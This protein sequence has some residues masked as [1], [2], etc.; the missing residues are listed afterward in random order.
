[1]RVLYVSHFGGLGGAEHSLLELIMAVRP[2][3]V[4]PLLICPPGPLQ[5]MAVQNKIAVLNWAAHPLTRS[6][7]SSGL[8]R[9]LPRLARGWLRLVQTVE[10]FKPDVLHA[11][12]MQAML[13]IG[14]VARL[15]GCR[16]VWHW[17][18]FYDHRRQA[19]TVA[20]GADAIV[21]I[22]R[23]TLLFAADLLGPTSP[24]LSLIIN[25]V[26]DL[27]PC[28]TDQINAT[29]RSL[30]LLPDSLLVLMAGQS[31]PRKGHAVLIEAIATVNKKRSD[32]YALLL[33]QEH[34]RSAASYTRELRR[35][36][37]AL[38]C[39]ARVQIRDGIQPLAPML[40]AADIVAIPSL[41]EPFGRIAVE[42]MLARKPVIASDIDGLKEIV[43]APET[44]LLVPPGD[45][46]RLAS[47][48][49]DMLGARASLQLRGEAG[50]RRAQDRFAISR[51][52][53]EVV[54]LYTRVLSADLAGRF[55]LSVAAVK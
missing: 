38:G 35:Q 26:S 51:V 32:V 31:V 41:R 1:M 53:A 10:S 27:P 25:G 43:Q 39:D 12:S 22:S 34:D 45:A 18:D 36:S 3:G 37:T 29:R 5:D 19:R 7:G 2:L 14:P 11:N 23:S 52:A 30:G 48:L 9:S 33:C 55:D 8:P 42:A 24:K 20:R 49:L 54:S 21:A 44:G 28:D 4:E 17:R 13:W 47:G 50:R 46:A 40:H 15:R 6:R 16:V